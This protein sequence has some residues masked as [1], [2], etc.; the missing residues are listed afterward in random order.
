[1]PSHT[2][3][4]TVPKPGCGR[5]SHHTSRIVLMVSEEINVSITCSNCGQPLNSHG[6]P[7]VG[8]PSN[9]LDRHDAMPVSCPIQYGLDADRARKCGM[10]ADSALTIAIAFSPLRTP[11]CTWM[12]K[13]CICLAGHCMS[14]TSRRY[15]GSGL[16]SWSAGS[17]NGWV[18]E[19]VSETLRG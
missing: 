19:D 11:T 15:R 4:S 1:M 10:Y 7:A 14:F 17:L 16:I 6:G 5:M 12:P 13:I 2:R 18:P 9:T 8:R 3:I